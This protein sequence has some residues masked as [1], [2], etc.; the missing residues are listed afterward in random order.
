[1]AKFSKQHY[2][3]IAGELHLARLPR[4]KENFRSR[5]GL[6]DELAEHLAVEFEHD[7]SRFNR[8]HFLAVVRGERPVMSRPPRS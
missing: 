1:M 5:E 7:N 6:I 2:Q 8:E 3:A 4:E